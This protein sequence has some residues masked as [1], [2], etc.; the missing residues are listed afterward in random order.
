MK[1]SQEQIKETLLKSNMP[2]FKENIDQAEILIEGL[3]EFLLIPVNQ[4]Y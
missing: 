1:V 3:S 4:N 2:E